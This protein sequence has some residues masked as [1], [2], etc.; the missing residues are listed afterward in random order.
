MAHT[1]TLLRQY[2]SCLAFVFVSPLLTS[3][4]LI[5]LNSFDESICTATALRTPRCCED[6][7]IVALLHEGISLSQLLGPPHKIITPF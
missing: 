3:C 2:F 7:L 1:G 6:N 5:C 4:F